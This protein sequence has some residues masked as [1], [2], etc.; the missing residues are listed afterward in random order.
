[1]TIYQL[2]KD[3]AEEIEKIMSGMVF[4]NPQ[5][6]PA[7]MKAYLQNLPKRE[8]TV[9]PGNLM[10]EDED[11]D[12]YPFCIVRMESGG[13]YSGAQRAQIILVFGIFDDNMDNLGHQALLNMIHRVAEHFIKNSVLKDMHQMDVEKGINWILD[14]EERYPYYIGGLEMT[15]DTCF[16]ERGEDRYA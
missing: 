7:Q 11:E 5:G 3:L 9:S 2:Q 12:P 13:V 4:K 10:P 16:V 14:D 8:Q 6:E 1:M 15:W